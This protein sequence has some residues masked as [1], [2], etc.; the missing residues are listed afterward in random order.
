[1]GVV[2]E[3]VQDEEGP[4]LRADAAEAVHTTKDSCVHA[5]DDELGAEAQRTDSGGGV[6]GLDEV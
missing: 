1:M 2:D 5:R 4:I 3:G 6:V